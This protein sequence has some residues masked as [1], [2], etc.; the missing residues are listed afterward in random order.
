[1]DK[2]DFIIISQSE[3]LRYEDY[4]SMP[5]E[6]IDL[7]RNLVQLRMVYYDSGFRSHLDMFNKAL[8]NKYFHEASYE[9]KRRLFIIWNL[10]CLNGIL[11]IG[12]LLNSGFNCKIINNFDAEFDLLIGYCKKMDPPIIGISTTFILQW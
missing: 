6:R 11:A 3:V 5:L 12:P 4:S 2:L 1:M 9:E 8:Y 7:Y 10:S